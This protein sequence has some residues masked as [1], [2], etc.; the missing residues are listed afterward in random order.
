MGDPGI[1]PNE[2]A[3]DKFIHYFMHENLLYNTTGI[4]KLILSVAVRM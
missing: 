2:L 4:K 3:L 1:I